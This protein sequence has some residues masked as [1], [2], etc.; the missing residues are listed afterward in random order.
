[1]RDAGFADV[2]HQRFRFPLG[3]WPKDPKM[4]EIG[5]FNYAQVMGGLE[6]F[7]LRLFCHV[8][9]WK[10]EEVLVLLA[11]VRAELKDPK[12]HVQFDL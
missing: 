12:L 10:A 9:G 7:S 5:M 6:A 11:K 8:L 3:A 4:K 1:M 2:T